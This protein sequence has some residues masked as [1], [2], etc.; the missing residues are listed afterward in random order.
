MER[1]KEKQKPEPLFCIRIRINF[2][3]LDVDQNTGR[4]KIPTKE[5]KSNELYCCQVLDVLV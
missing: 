4:Q 3:R 1:R 2:G 5:E